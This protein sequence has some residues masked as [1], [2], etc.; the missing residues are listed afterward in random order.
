MLSADFA[1][2]AE[3]A[4]RMVDCGADWLHMDVMVRGVGGATQA[5]QESGRGRKSPAR[6]HPRLAAFLQDG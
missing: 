1:R 5:V 4:K 2:L 3:E 6:R